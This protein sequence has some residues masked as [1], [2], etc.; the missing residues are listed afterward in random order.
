MGEI[1]VIE[2]LLLVLIDHFTF[3]TFI[4]IKE[5]K[6]KHVTVEKT[7]RLHSK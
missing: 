4:D 6:T 5:M 7:S 2:E 1:E 3:V